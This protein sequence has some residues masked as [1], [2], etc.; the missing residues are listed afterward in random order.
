MIGSIVP[1]TCFLRVHRHRPV[2]NLVA[3]KVEA[4][5]LTVVR[6]AAIDIE[7]LANEVSLSVWHERVLILELDVSTGMAIPRVRL[8][9]IEIKLLVSCRLNEGP[10]VFLDVV[11]PDVAHE[12]F[13]ARS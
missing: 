6:K 12:L 5:C 1:Q 13:T 10:E 7:V 4:S 9:H 11:H 2:W 8:L 3:P